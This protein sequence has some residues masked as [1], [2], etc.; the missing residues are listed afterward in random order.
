MLCQIFVSTDEDKRHPK[1]TE[2]L[3]YQRWR[4]GLYRGTLGVLAGAA[5][6]TS[7]PLEAVGKLLGS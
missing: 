7:T 3:A 5:F 2:T 1:R 6:W 4:D